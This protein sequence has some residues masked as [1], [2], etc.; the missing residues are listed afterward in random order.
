MRLE[1]HCLQF[2]YLPAGD[3]IYFTDKFR[4]WNVLYLQI[5]KN[6]KEIKQKNIGI[7]HVF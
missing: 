7:Q 4:R 6:K 3:W 2:S 1:W 5:C